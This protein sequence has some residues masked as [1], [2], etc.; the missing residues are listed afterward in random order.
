MNYTEIRDLSFAYADRSDVLTLGQYDNFLRLVESRVSRVLKTRKMTKRST[1]PT[2]ATSGYYGLP[3]AFLA[4]RDI[5]VNFA[6]SSTNG[7]AVA[8]L[9]FLSPEQMNNQANITDLP[10]NRGIFYNITDDQLHILPEIPSGNTIEMVYY[11]RVPSLTA[12]VPNN[13]ISDLH[14]DVYTFGVLVEISAFVKDVAAG[15]MW[16]QRY[17]NALSEIVS[18]DKESRWGLGTSMRVRPV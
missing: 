1:L 10:E 14:P 2:G 4:M 11:V 6:N 13:W 7:K 5:Q 15:N 8:T 18:D 12:A 16:E 17:T 3:P 9:R